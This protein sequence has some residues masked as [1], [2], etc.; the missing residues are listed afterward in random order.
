MRRSKVAKMNRMSMNLLISYLSVL[1]IPLAAI[2]II[3]FTASRLLLTVQMEKMNNTLRM[4]AQDVRQSIEEA[5]NLGA[6]ISTSGELSDLCSRIDRGE[7]YYDMYEYTRTLSDYSMF[8]TSIESVYTFFMQGGYLVKNL[9]VVPADERGY[10]SVGRFSSDSLEELMNLFGENHFNKKIFNMRQEA[11]GDNKLAVAQTIPY[12]PFGTPQGTLVVIIS[13][14][15]LE[16]QLASNLIQ[17]EGIT[18]MISREKEGAAV[19]KAIVGE[20]SQ[21]SYEKVPV[22]DILKRKPDSVS[23]GGV[24]YMVCT[25][26]DKLYPYSYISLVPK[27]TV[28]GQ[29]GYIKY[30]IIALCVCSILMGIGVCV[31]LWR[32]RRSVVLAFSRYEDEF[33]VAQGNRSGVRSLWEG[34]PHLLDSAVNLQTTLKL[35]QRFMRSAVFRKMLFGEYASRRELEQD[36][37]NA[38]VILEGNGYYVAVIACRGDA[39][40]DDMERWNDLRLRIREYFNDHISI[41]NHYCDLDLLRAAVIFPV[42]AVGKN[43]GESL[44]IIKEML[45]GYREILLEE[46][47]LETYIGVGREVAERLEI[48]TSYDDAKEISQYLA[49]HDIRTVMDKE[50]MPRQT[51][52]FFFPIETE[53]HLVK[54]IKQGNQEEL[55]DIFR[56]L[57]FEN[58]TYRKLSVTMAGHLTELV[59]ATAVRALREEGDSYEDVMDELGRLGDLEEIHKLLQRVLPGISKSMK[60]MEEQSAD[61]MKQELKDLVEKLF[62]RQD[63]TLCQLAEAVGMSENKLYKQF[64]VLF[65]MSFSEYLE[66]ERIKKACVLLKEQMPVKDVAETVGYGSDFSFR[67]AFKRVMGLAPSYYAEGLEEK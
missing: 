43:R 36:L 46:Q 39:V 38:D 2:I 17:G 3:Y 11:G 24:P 42:M 58:F 20:K 15:R 26:E 7:V 62:S 10:R 54:V 53:L 12:T 52:H 14:A 6:Y 27:Q 28:L 56:M 59:R 5:G 1:A 57:H 33:G 41:P 22:E 8:N 21:V 60:Q 65:G 45:T 40:E 18:L 23:I 13:D 30:L 67:R 37:Q 44:A 63:F 49:F 50:E 16:N 66:N 4:T 47:E 64:K 51:D 61:Y 29:I 34:I 25:Y 31:G 9:V 19:Q 32:S 48:A 55:A 35:Q